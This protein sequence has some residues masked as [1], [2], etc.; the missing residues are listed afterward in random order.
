M[1]HD[2]AVVRV[3]LGNFQCQVLGERV[4]HGVE[5]L[6]RGQ[7]AHGQAVLHALL[8]PQEE[9]LPVGPVADALHAVHVVGK[10]VRKVPAQIQRVPVL[11][12]G[13]VVLAA[14]L[15]GGGQVGVGLRGV[16]GEDAHL[17]EA[18][19]GLL[20]PPL[21]LEDAAEVVVDDAE[22]LH[23]RG[24]VEEGGQ[25]P[26]VDRGRR[27]QA[28]L[29]ADARRVAADGVVQKARLPQRVAQIVVDL[30]KVGVHLNGLLVGLDGQ[31]ESPL[32]VVHP[33]EVGQGHGV[34]PV[35]ADDLRVAPLGLG[36]L[37]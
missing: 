30:W 37:L 15:V 35:H 3:G 14:V 25:G 8:Q 27:R 10:G 36:E 26:P 1:A 2:L 13:V 5:R 29:D 33:G 17:L 24:G 18:G 31:V 21:D 32:L 16:R 11:H 22:A 12:N 23:G 6:H 4:G 20:H 34:L 28:A 19:H 7:R 9:R